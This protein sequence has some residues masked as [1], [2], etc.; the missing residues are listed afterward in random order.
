MKR[1][2]LLVMKH[3]GKPAD[4]GDVTSTLGMYAEACRILLQLVKH[5]VRRK[6][7]DKNV[8]LIH[9][10]VF[11]QRDFNTIIKSKCKS[12]KHSTIC[13]SNFQS[14]IL[15]QYTFPFIT[16]SPF[17]PADIS[18]IQAVLEEAVKLIPNATNSNV[19]KSLAKI[20][21]NMDVFKGLRVGVDSKNRKRTMSSN[22]SYSN[23]S[24]ISDSTM[25]GMEDY[26]FTYEEEADP[27][28]FFMPYIWEVIVS[29]VTSNSVEWN[30]VKIKAFTIL[31][32]AEAS[33]EENENAMTTTEFAENVDDVV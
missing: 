21:E 32:H 13:F 27:E 29:T 30:K 9:A 24:T 33:S 19:E 23:D 1:Y 20:K 31:H 10:L 8:H 26:K 5:S 17:R 7:V 6:V 12:W 11:N 16:A 4:D 2:T 14:R 15:T 22:S 25:N 28:T 3:G 18:K